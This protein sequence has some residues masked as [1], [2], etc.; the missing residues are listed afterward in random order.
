M[1][2]RARRLILA[3]ALLLGLAAGMTAQW[4]DPYTRRLDRVGV[5]CF[6]DGACTDGSCAPGA[7]CD[8]KQLGEAGEAP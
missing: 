3:A 6:E 4:W 2:R 5:Q 8:D 1:T 7:A